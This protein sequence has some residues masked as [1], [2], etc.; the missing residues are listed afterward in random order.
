M[1]VR[2]DVVIVGT[3]HAGAQ[4]AIALRQR[5]FEGTIALIGDERDPP[6]ERPP[7]SKDYLT[8]EKPFDRMLIRPERFWD[9]R[10]ITLLLGRRVAAVDAQEHRLTLAEGGVMEYGALIWAAGATPRRLAC[11]GH[12]LS[13]VHSIRTRA[14]VDRLVMELPAASRIVVVG[15]GYIGLEAAAALAKLGKRVVILEAQDRVLSRVAGEPI[16]RFFEAEH[17]ARGTEIRLS[18]TVAGL[19]QARGAV[20]GVRLADGRLIDCEMVIVGIGIVPAVAP[21]RAAG[22]VGENG[23]MVDAHCRTSLPDIFAIGDCA[24]HRNI[25]ADGAVIR[26]ESVQNA[27]DQAATVAKAL[28]GAAEP[29]DAVPWFWSNQFDFK[30][31]TVGLSV[32][33]DQ[34]VLRGDP[35]TGAFTVVYLKRGRVIALD[36]VNNVKDYIQGRSL[37]ESRAEVD[38][39][40]LSDMRT[41]LKE[42]FPR[43]EAA[44]IPATL[45][46]ASPAPA[47]TC[48]VS[49]RDL[50]ILADI[51]AYHHEIG[52]PQPLVVHVTLAVVPP[53]RDSVE[54][55]FDYVHI[56]SL[57]EK[58][59]VQRIVLIETFAKRLAEACLEHRLI[60]G[61]V[62]TV[63]KPRAVPGA[64]A[65]A[66]VAVGS[67]VLKSGEGAGLR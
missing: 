1:T 38:P 24:A 7:L 47:S 12:D 41:A 40:P 43:G 9:E 37:V 56:K 46:K 60:Q 14:D 30:L 54:D 13:G 10:G 23:V 8:G 58:L 4:A 25:Y 20:R 22:A 16:S 64:M 11:P 45:I 49:L 61:A 63:E 26:L 65:S 33:H 27:S 31:Q 19:E 53:E 17:R 59:S 36:C 50:Q 48:S 29:Y 67:C 5:K 28:T 18:A 3:G 39:G 55:V 15:G 21:L 42:L 57:A 62:V 44:A 34:A 2:H 6:Y 66:T 35:S 32:G 52:R 51:G